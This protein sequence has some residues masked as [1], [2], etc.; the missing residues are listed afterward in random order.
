MPSPLLARRLYRHFFGDDF[1]IA[2]DFLINQL[3]DLTEFFVSDRFKVGKIKPKLLIINERAPL[4]DVPILPAALREA[5]A[6][7]SDALQWRLAWLLQHPHHTED[8]PR[9]SLPPP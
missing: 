1:R 3:L 8:R 6:S 7:P 5:D 4:V 2:Q 9:A